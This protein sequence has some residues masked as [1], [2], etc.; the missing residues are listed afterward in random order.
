MQTPNWTGVIPAVL[1]HFHEDFSID[2]D[3]TIEHI[4]YQLQKGIHGMVVMGTC[5]ENNTLEEDEKQE[6]LS[7]I[8]A[9]VDGRVPVIV[10]VSELSTQKAARFAKAA[11]PICDGFMVLPAMACSRT[12]LALPSHTGFP[13]T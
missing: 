5:G 1:T 3:A 4:E 9:H 12:S 13:S 11:E 8:Y 2:Y 7:R 6:V 10:G